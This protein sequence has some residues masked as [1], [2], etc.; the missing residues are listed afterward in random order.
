MEQVPKAAPRRISRLLT[1]MLTVKARHEEM[2]IQAVCFLLPALLRMSSTAQGCEALVRQ[3]GHKQ[4]RGK[5]K[6]G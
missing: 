2:P 3:G 1:F 5:G 6:V 4:V